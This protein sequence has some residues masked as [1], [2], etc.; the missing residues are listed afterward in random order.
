MYEKKDV[1]KE[2]KEIKGMFSALATLER[3]RTSFFLVFCFLISLQ[4]SSFTSY[5][6][7]TY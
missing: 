5:Y 6:T 7:Y 4:F 1:K 2:K 3:E